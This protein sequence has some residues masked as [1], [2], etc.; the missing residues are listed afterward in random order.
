MLRFHARPGHTVS[1]PGTKF[2][3]QRARYV[4]RTTKIEK[5]AAGAVVAIS[6]PA[7]EEPACVDPDSKDRFEREKAARLLRLMAIESVK[8]LLPADEATAKACG[9]P[10]VPVELRDGEWLPKPKITS[11][12]KE[13]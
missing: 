1:W 12:S 5:D 9:I 2:A 6:H 7:V 13:A 4:G 3:G 8:P 10:F 11:T